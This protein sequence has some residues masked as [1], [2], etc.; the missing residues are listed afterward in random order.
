MGHVT[1]FCNCSR[2]V[3]PFLAL[4]FHAEPRARITCVWRAACL[5]LPLLVVPFLMVLL[6]T[7][8]LG[9]VVFP[10]TRKA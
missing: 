3:R 10:A 2:Q 5:P 7:Y 6:F 1:C 8:A 9:G 4:M